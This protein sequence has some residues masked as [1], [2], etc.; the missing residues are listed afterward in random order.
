M[1]VASASVRAKSNEA[2]PHYPRLLFPRNY[3]VVL[4][5]RWLHSIPNRIEGGQ[6]YEDQGSSTSGP[7]DECVGQRTPEYGLSQRYEGQNRGE[8]SQ[9][10]RASMDVC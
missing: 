10:H 8:S 7:A 6:K 3:Q 9:N 5:Y 4:R 2:T 1:D